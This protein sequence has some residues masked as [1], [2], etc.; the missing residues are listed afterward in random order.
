MLTGC[1]CAQRDDTKPPT[2]PHSRVIIVKFLYKKKIHNV[3]GLT[4]MLLT[5]C[6]SFSP[7]IIHI[8]NPMACFRDGDCTRNFHE[9]EI[10]SRPTA[11]FQTRSNSSEWHE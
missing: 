8:G 4:S 1:M 9:Y 3:I 6:V 5:H 7:Y 2:K 11:L 10:P